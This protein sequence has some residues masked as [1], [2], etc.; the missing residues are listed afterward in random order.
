[1]R[2]KDFHL[3]Y[4][5][6]IVLFSRVFYEADSLESFPEAMRSCLQQDYRGKFY[7]DFY[8]AAVQSERLDDWACVLPQLKQLFNNWQT[9]VLAYHQDIHTGINIPKVYFYLL[10]RNLLLIV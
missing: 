1:M 5:V 8:R 10:I 6:T 3:D 9:N 4:Q 7:E 2:F